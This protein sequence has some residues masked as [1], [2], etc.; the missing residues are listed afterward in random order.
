MTDPQREDFC[1]IKQAAHE[2]MQDDAVRYQRLVRWA[3]SARGK[4]PKAFDAL[5]AWLLDDAAWQGTRLA[6]SAQRLMQEVIGRFRAQNAY[7]RAELAA[8]GPLEQVNQAVFSAID[9]FDAALNGEVEG[10][11]LHSAVTRLFTEPASLEDRTLRA[12]IAGRKTGAYGTDTVGDEGYINVLEGLDAGVQWALFMPDV[13]KRQQNGFRVTRFEYRRMPA[14]RFVG[15]EAAEADE[16]TRR[17]VF[18]TLDAMKEYRSGFDADLLFMHHYGLGVDVGAWHGFWGRFMREG[19][20]VPEGFVSFDLTPQRTGEAGAPFI[21]QFAYAVFDGD[22][23]AMHRR[24]G[25]DSDAMYDVTRNIML[26]QGVCI[27]YPE[28]YWTAEVF[29]EGW[30]KPG[31]AYLFSAEL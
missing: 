2:G 5:N 11:P 26:A 1:W 28:K 31:I 13:V 24:E 15:R 17:Q 25:F 10:E 22:A 18:E 29:P 4:N 7:L 14:M 6:A 16:Q 9:R 23:Q 8:L 19:A 12:Q 20:P 27:P 30:E 3:S 21:A